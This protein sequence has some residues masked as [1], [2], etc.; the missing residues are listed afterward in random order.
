MN[1]VCVQLE[2][3]FEF[4]CPGIQSEHY[5]DGAQD[6]IQRLVDPDFLTPDPH[7]LAMQRARFADL[8]PLITW[9]DLTKAPCALSVLLLSKYRHNGSQFFYEMISRWLLPGRN[10]NVELFFA[11]DIRLP[12]LSDDLLS[13]AEI[14]VYLKSASD[15][16]EVKRHLKAVETE[17]RLG[18][19]SHYHA[20]KILEFKGLSS[21]GKTAMIQEKIGSLIH[22]HSK[23]FDQ[24]IFAQ[25]QQFLV[26]CPE[27]FKQERDY[28]HI[29]RII[30]NL[31]SMSKVLQQ[32]ASLPSKRSVHVKFLKTNLKS[33]TGSRPVLG[34]LVGLGFLKEH[35]VFE[36]SHLLNSIQTVCFKATLVSGSVL[37][38]RGGGNPYQTLYLEVQKANEFTHDEIQRLR[39][40]LP[41]AIKQHVESLMHPIFM[42]RNEEEVLRNIMALSRQIRFLSDPP[43]V[44]LSFDGQTAETIGFT[45]IL[46]KV[47]TEDQPTVQ[48]ILKASGSLLPYIA[49]RVRRV[50]SLRRKY[51]KEATVFR[52]N[53]ESRPFLR[54]DRSIDL[55]KAREFVFAELNRVIGSLR[56]YNGGM[57]VKQ[58]ETLSELK[59]SLG[60]IGKEK[61]LCLEQFYYGLAP[62]EMRTSV[63]I[64]ALKQLFLLLLQAVES[65]DKCYAKDELLCKYMAGPASLVPQ[66]MEGAK[67]HEFV[68]SMVEEG[69]VSYR[70]SLCFSLV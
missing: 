15:A 59:R 37:S 10:L 29:S 4:G 1:Q 46:L 40:A 19:V 2:F 20:R 69:G 36:A 22:S 56:D 5:R 8:L 24:G 38:D 67:P 39:E 45:V 34:V 57:I 3:D 11:S 6:L 68:T 62:I 58:S 48:E 7:R 52:T 43:Q 9:S 14:V 13:V 35:E 12:H 49:D 23:D 42:P 17:I 64:E 61:L 33:A 50:G 31:Y 21:D 60:K 18:I 66:S 26:Q 28:H 16:E 63:D 54:S 44:I 51:V 32:G 27:K 55:Y 30:S 53:V 65:G 47:T 25:M 70:A 41:E